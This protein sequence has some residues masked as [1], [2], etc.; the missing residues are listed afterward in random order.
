MTSVHKLKTM[1]KLLIL[2]LVVSSTAFGQNKL[3]KLL[4][5][6]N[7][8]KV[9]YMSVETLAMPK[10]KAILLDAREAKE[11]NVSHLKNAIWV[12]YKD[13]DEQKIL[14]IIPNTSQPIIVYCSIG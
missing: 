8:N 7:K 1:K 11:Y 10:T 4:Q 12:G 6:W 3:D 5:K 13:F 9:P 2:F 14:E